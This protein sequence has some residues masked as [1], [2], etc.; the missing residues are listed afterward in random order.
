MKKRKLVSL[1][2]CA[3]M[4]ATALTGGGSGGD[5][6]NSAETQSDGKEPVSISF[7]TAAT[8]GTVYPLGSAIATLWNDELD[9]VTASAT[10]SNGGVENLNCIRDGEAQIGVAVTSIM[11]E[12]MNGTGVFEGNADPNLRV[13]A[14]LYYNPNQVVVS[15]ESGIETLNDLKGKR[16]APGS[17]GGTSE[18]ETNYHLTALG[19]NYPDDIDAQYV[20]FTEAS[21]LLRNKQLD[22]AWIMAG[23]PTAAVTEITATAGGKLVPMDE[24][25]IEK[26]QETY[27]W[28]AKYTIPAGTYSGQDQDVLTS[29]IKITLC[30]SADVPEDVI[31]DLTKTFWENIDTLSQSQS[32]LKSCSVEEAV[33]D[34][35]GLPIHDG[36][37]KYYKEIGVLE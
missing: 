21:D 3:A 36:A 34:L 19:M 18:V 20:G 33:T 37:A 2:L 4:L 22:G 23:V 1:T 25:L 29:A 27:P 10:A 26:L 14:G 30:T 16:F 13:L 11:Y 28:Y 12:S 35:A 5:S 17:P 8:T 32:I 24:A 6:Q 31:Y 7:M 9:Y 15:A